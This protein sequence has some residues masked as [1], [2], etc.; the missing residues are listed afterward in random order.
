MK[1]LDEIGRTLVSK[2]LS[3]TKKIRKA[4][5]KFSQMV[6]LKTL[7]K[8]PKKY[9]HG[10]PEFSLVFSWPLASGLASAGRA[11]RKQFQFIFKFLNK[12]TIYLLL[13]L[14]P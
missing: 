10:S 4:G 8:E 9:P 11:K 7:E 12:Y 3:Q 14:F 5:G 13:S 1:E 6:G 2:A